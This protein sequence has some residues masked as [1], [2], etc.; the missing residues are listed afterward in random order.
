M[1]YIKDDFLDLELFNTLWDQIDLDNFTNIEVPTGTKDYDLIINYHPV[2][3]KFIKYLVKWLSIIEDADIESIACFIRKATDTID[4]NW[5][6][7]NDGYIQGQKPDRACVLYLSDTQLKELH[8]TAFWSHVEHGEY[9]NDLSNVK[10]YDKLIKED[11]N[12]I[13]KWD[14]KSVIGYKKN[15]LISYPSNYFHSKYPNQAWETGRIALIMFYKS[16]N[17]LKL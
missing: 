6:I 15:R 17:S 7:H 16:T 14:L 10:E 4:T 12:N 13:E 3:L 2:P 5:Q 11:F 9:F 8:G 1:I